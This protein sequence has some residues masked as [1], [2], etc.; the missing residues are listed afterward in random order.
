MQFIEFAFFAIRPDQPGHKNNH[1]ENNK[2]D[3]SRCKHATNIGIKKI[4]DFNVRASPTM[5]FK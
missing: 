4:N 5:F 3:P 1:K 2:G